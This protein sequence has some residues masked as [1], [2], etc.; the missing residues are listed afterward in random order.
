MIVAC[1]LKRAH[2]NIPLAG[3]PIDPLTPL[4]IISPTGQYVRNDNASN[5]A[6]VGNGTGL[7]APERYIAYHPTNPFTDASP[8]DP[9][10]TCYLKNEAT[11]LYCQLR[12][13]P[14]NSTQIGERLALARRVHHASG[15]SRP[16]SAC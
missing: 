5:F 15:W 1:D 8:I 13:L 16:E 14:T 9:Y 4:N 6:Y 2:I 12:P 11:G 3:P 10:E 7:T